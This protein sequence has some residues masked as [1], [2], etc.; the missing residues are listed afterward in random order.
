M[1]SENVRRWREPYIDKD[2]G[3]APASSTPGVLPFL[4]TLPDPEVH[5]DRESIPGTAKGAPLSASC[6]GP[7]SDR[8]YS[9]RLGTLHGS[10]PCPVHLVL[11]HDLLEHSF[12]VRSCV[13]ESPL[14]LRRG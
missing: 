5:H 11:A 7:G 12:Q 4:G 8:E 14:K 13:W 9:R 1:T 3:V 2:T 10:L 6:I